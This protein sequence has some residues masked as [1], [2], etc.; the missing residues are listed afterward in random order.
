[1]VSALVRHAVH[2]RPGAF[3]SSAPLRACPAAS[4]DSLPHG[5]ACRADPGAGDARVQNTLEDMLRLQIDKEELKQMVAE[6]GAKL[7][8]T[9]EE[10]RLLQYI[11]QQTRP[12]PACTLEPVLR[13]VTPAVQSPP[14]LC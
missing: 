3:H 1:M 12:S 8:L 7:R 5:R 6:E 13:T 14:V 10:V 2:V 9:A 4:R 11:K